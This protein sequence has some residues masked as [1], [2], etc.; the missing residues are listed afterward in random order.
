MTDTLKSISEQCTQLNNPRLDFVPG[1]LPRH[2]D[3]ILRDL[4]E[5]LA[6]ASL[7]LEKTVVILSGSILE[8][9]L[10]TLIQGQQPYIAARRGHP[11]QFD[12]EQGLA[13]FVSIF[14]R[15][16]RGALLQTE[17]PDIVVEYRNLVHFHREMSAPPGF[18]AQGSREM[19]RILE[20]LLADLAS[21][22]RPFAPDEAAPA[23]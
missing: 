14:N 10:F 3:A 15:Y 21:I 17:L 13:N 6:A 20:G 11:F 12:P 19:L 2:R 23:N 7:E 9:V 5:L 18:C 22:S 4:R 16:F 1:G 8:G